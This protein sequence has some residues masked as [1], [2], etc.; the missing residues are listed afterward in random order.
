MGESQACLKYFGEVPVRK[1]KNLEAISK[2]K[3][4]KI[5]HVNVLK[6]IQSTTCH[7]FKETAGNFETRAA[8]RPVEIVVF[9]EQNLSKAALQEL[10]MALTWLKRNFYTLSQLSANCLHHSLSI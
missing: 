2:W 10:F 6:H 3:S 8:A 5:R 7:V 4:N 9:C 1:H